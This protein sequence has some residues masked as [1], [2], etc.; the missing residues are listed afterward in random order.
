MWRGTTGATGACHSGAAT[1]SWRPFDGE[2]LDNSLTP[3]AGPS[4]VIASKVLSPVCLRGRVREGAGGVGSRV[5]HENDGGGCRPTRSRARGPQLA[6][7]SGPPRAGPPRLRPTSG[8]RPRRR[9][10]SVRHSR[11]GGN[12]GRGAWVPVSSTRMTE[13]AAA[14]PVCEREVLGERGPAVRPGLGRF[15]CGGHSQDAHVVASRASVIP[16]Q[17]GIQGVGEWVPVS[18]TRMTEGAAALPVC[19]REVLGERGPAV[20]PGLGRLDCGGHPQH[21]HVVASR[22]HDLH[23]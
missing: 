18:S 10:A 1:R 8:A 23:R 12:P 2:H 15:D 13:G 17:A 6:W 5:K 19:E 14:L 4:S 9:L 20:R 3:S 21:A 11:A 7:A 16:A 22:A